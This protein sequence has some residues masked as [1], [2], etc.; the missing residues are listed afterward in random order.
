MNWEFTDYVTEVR[1]NIYESVVMNPKTDVIVL[2]YKS[3][4][5]YSQQVIKTM[6]NNIYY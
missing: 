1:P 3:D 4:C 5:P 6:I 2:Y